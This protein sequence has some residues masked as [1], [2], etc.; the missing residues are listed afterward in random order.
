MELAFIRTALQESLWVKERILADGSLLE[1][2]ARAGSLLVQTFKEGK[3][4]LLCGNG[5]SAADAQ[6]IAAELTGR[7]LKDRPPL[8]A[9]ALHGNTSFLTAVANDYSFTEVFARII[10]ARGRPGD[11]LIAISTSGNSP[12]ILKAL[13]T[14]RAMGMRT[15]GLSGETGGEMSP[16]CDLLIRVPSRETPRIQEA[17]ITIGHI[18]CA[19]V[20]QKLFGGGMTQFNLKE[21]YP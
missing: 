6:H 1:T 18:L 19:W 11:L 21:S 10:R 12:N 17:H 9:E 3:K 8:D 15:L 4:V 7:F 2:I 13:A 20:E 5:G 14:A 16:L